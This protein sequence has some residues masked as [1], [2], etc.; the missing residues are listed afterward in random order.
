MLPNRLSLIHGYPADLSFSV[1][2]GADSGH[3]YLLK[4][5]LMTAQQ[6]SLSIDM[7]M[8]TVNHILTKLLYLSPERSLL[9]VTD[10]RDDGRPSHNFEHLSCFLPGLLALGV[11][12]LPHSV[13]TN[14]TNQTPTQQALLFPYK[15]KDLQMWAA[16]GLGETCWLMYADQPTGLGPEEVAMKH[17]VE[18]EH[19][20]VTSN[21]N[22]LWIHAMEKWRI[23]GREGTPPGIDP[24]Q[25]AAQRDYEMR[26]PEY[27]LRPETIESMF[28]LWKVTG[29]MRWRERGWAIFEALE[30]ETKTEAGYVLLKSVE[31]SSGPQTDD[32]PSYFLAETLK[33]LYLLF[34]NEDRIPLDMWVFNTEAHPLPIFAWTPWEEDKFGIKR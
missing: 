19:P 3:E 25:G 23:G 32:M 29:D 6:N 28:Y 34:L 17:P 26:K 13:F 18:R 22:G 7:Y 5:Y 21:S 31:E 15:M 8:R 4:Y 30:R 20:E 33:Y 10:T 2:G 1:G 12:S 27:L 14:I 16:V 9:Y 11:H 24:E